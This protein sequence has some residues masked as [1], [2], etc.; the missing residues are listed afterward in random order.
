[1]EEGEGPHGSWAG[2]EPAILSE[3]SGVVAVAKP[4]GLPT[5]APAGIPSAESWLRQRQSAAGLGGAAYVG[6]PHRLDRAVSGLL[7]LATTPR[8]AR[9]LSRQFERRE[10]GKRYLALLASD[11]SPTALALVASLEASPAGIEWRDRME[12]V[13][14]EPRAR[15]VVSTGG[16]GRE[17]ITRARL[18]GVLPAGT[19]LVTLE[20]ST[21]RMHQ[22]RLQAAARGLPIVGDNLYGGG[23]AGG[24]A[25]AAVGSFG[26]PAVDP[27]LQAIGLHASRVS[28]TDPDTGQRTTIEAPPPI[29][30]PAEVPLLI[31]SVAGH[32]GGSPPAW[33]SH[34]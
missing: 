1:M 20:P 28:Y 29:F 34:C 9:K 6:V 17:A 18:L 26:P 24:Q 3:A 25:P 23:Q 16:G 11:G 19:L 4:A 8:A 30:W 10:I 12:K 27:R 32:D 33:V 14:D 5:Q 7:L 31:A 22:L 21:G 15:I 13:P 2:P